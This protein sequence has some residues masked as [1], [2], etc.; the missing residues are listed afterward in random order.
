MIKGIGIS[1]NY[2]GIFSNLKN[3]KYIN[4]CV[5]M[6]KGNDLLRDYY[7]TVK[8]FLKEDEMI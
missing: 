8:K 5:G 3:Y 2:V 6:K 7:R 4:Q 1:Q